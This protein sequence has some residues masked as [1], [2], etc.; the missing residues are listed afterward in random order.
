[1]YFKQNRLFGM[2]KKNKE[3]DYKNWISF[4]GKHLLKLYFI[5]LQLKISFFKKVHHLKGFVIKVKFCSEFQVT[6][7]TKSSKFHKVTV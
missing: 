5:S 6:V 2:K 4:E 1:M 3:E 7:Y